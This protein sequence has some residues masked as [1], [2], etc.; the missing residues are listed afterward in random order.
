MPLAARVSFFDWKQPRIVDSSRWFCELLKG[1][2]WLQDPNLVQYHA[3][4][5]VIPK[6]HFY[7]RGIE[8]IFMTVLKPLQL[9]RTSQLPGI[10]Y[11]AKNFGGA[12]Y[13]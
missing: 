2:L 10:L 12:I 9:E 4:W 13:E 6:N 3:R 11:D 8:I 5:V 7:L 1:I